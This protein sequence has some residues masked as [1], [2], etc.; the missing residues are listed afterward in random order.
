MS[1]LTPG[2]KAGSNRSR[3]RVFVNVFLDQLSCQSSNPNFELLWRSSSGAWV[4]WFWSAGSAVENVSIE[5]VI[6]DS[7]ACSSHGSLLVHV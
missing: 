5:G 7:V 2:T 1:I 6:D 3:V 4:C